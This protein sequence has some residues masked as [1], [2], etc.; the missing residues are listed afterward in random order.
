VHWEVETEQLRGLVPDAFK[1]DLFDGKAYVGCVPF[2]MEDVRASFMPFGFDFYEL[3]LRTYVTYNGQPGVYFFSLDAASWPM[4]KLI[5]SVFGMNYCH[6]S[7]S[8]STG[9]PPVSCSWSRA[10][11]RK[12][13]FS[14]PDGPVHYSSV[15]KSDGTKLEVTYEVGEALGKSDNGTLQ[16]FLFER[17][18][19]FTLQPSGIYQAQVHHPPYKVQSAKIKDLEETLLASAGLTMKKGTELLAHFSEGVNVP[20]Y[21][22]WRVGP[23]DWG[24]CL[25]PLFICFDGILS[26]CCPI[27][28]PH[29]KKKKKR[30][31]SD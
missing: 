1:L 30:L 25:D 2:R 10:S 7:M 18:H 29:Q 15:R 12:L 5:K 31:K 11:S 16:F 24:R 21:G 27:V 9:Q 26:C 14:V 13:P 6:A 3:N 19:L 28:L 8:C 4:V 23:K 17:Y 22:P 20:S